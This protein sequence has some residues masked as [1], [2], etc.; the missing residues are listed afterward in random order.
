VLFCLTFLRGTAAPAKY[1]ADEDTE[2]LLVNHNHAASVCAGAEREGT[3]PRA[4][5][6]WCV[7]GVFGRRL[8]APAPSK[9][10]QTDPGAD[11]RCVIVHVY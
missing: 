8:P 11:V 5:R 4:V 3:R 1:G 10:N 7:L 2:M 9:K 6:M